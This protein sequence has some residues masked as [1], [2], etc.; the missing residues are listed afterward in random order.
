[1]AQRRR[2][3][4]VTWWGKKDGR[5]A[6]PGH[7]PLPPLPEDLANY[8]SYAL[9]RWE[10]SPSTHQTHIQCIFQSVRPIGGHNYFIKNLKWPRAGGWGEVSLCGSGKHKYST[11]AD[12]E[13]Y[14][15]GPYTKDGKH[16]SA[17]TAEETAFELGTFDPEADQDHGP[18]TLAEVIEGIKLIARCDDMATDP[19]IMTRYFMKKQW[20]VEMWH[21][22]HEEK[23]EV[24]IP[25][26][27]RRGWMD[28]IGELLTESAP[29]NRRVVWIWSDSSQRNKTTFMNY[30]Q[31]LDA[32]SVI[33]I[34]GLPDEKYIF[35]MV[36][37]D[38]R[39]I[40]FDCP[41]EVSQ[42][43]RERLIHLVEQC[44][45]HGFKTVCHYQARQVLV[46]CHVVVT[47]NWDPMTIQL[48]KRLLHVNVENDPA[49]FTD[50]V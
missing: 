9:G 14:V 17:I 7:I 19:R 11:P 46:K 26:A 30:I 36:T 42:A 31:S 16:K 37:R 8:F 32:H 48:P 24:E 12:L 35:S 38:T 45:N 39:I 28:K 49:V 40:W 1:M 25:E 47:A 13:A 2:T 18:T 50:D 22:F 21:R 23:F 27:E 43:Q 4:S 5:A 29:L 41:R 44:S 15:R 33:P 6:W 20:C 34:S 10:E 3:I